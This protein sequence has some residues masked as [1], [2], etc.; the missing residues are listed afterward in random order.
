MAPAWL[1][2]MAACTIAPAGMPSSAATAGMIVPTG[3][4]IGRSRGSFST[5]TPLV[6]TSTGSYSVAPS[7]RLSMSWR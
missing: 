5:S 7:M 6:A 1:S 4:S 2:L 3:S